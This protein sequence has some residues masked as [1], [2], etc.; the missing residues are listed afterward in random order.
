MIQG[1][2]NGDIFDYAKFIWGADRRTQLSLYG[3]IA[4]VKRIVAN[5]M[6]VWKF[7]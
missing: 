4:L 6:A 7:P 1:G 3:T 5:T 2:V